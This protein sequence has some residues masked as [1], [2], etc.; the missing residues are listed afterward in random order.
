M[1]DYLLP[2]GGVQ[3]TH[4]P[5]LATGNTTVEQ[6]VPAARLDV[7]IGLGAS[8]LLVI[9]VITFSAGTS[10]SQ[11]CLSGMGFLHMIWV[12]EHHPELSGILEQVEDPTTY[13]L[14]VAG[15]VKVRL[16]DALQIG[17]CNECSS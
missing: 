8:I 14:R 6:A 17:E 12:F 15:L 4:P 2:N 1:E 9:L 13:N 5:V 7:S 3:Q 10:S 16:A 11:P